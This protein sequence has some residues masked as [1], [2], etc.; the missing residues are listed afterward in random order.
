M[1]WIIMWHGV[2]SYIWTINNLENQKLIRFAT[3][4]HT[5]IPDKIS[6]KSDF[7]NQ[8]QDPIESASSRL[9]ELG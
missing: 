9:L 5:I 3:Q 8:A 7:Q 1:A 4:D 2:R 6:M